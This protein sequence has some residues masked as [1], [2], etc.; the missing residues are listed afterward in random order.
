M[1]KSYDWNIGY[2]LVVFNPVGLKKT[3]LN[4][5]LQ[6]TPVSW[7][8]LHAS[9]TFDQYGCE[10]PNGG[11]NDAG[12]A[13]ELMILGQTQYPAKDERPA[14][15]ELQFIQYALDNFASVE[16]MIEGAALIRISQAYAQVHYL[17]CDATGVCAAFEWLDGEL[18]LAT[19]DD[20]PAPTLANSTYADSA[21]YLAQF[22]G[23]GGSK[24]IPQSISS[25]DRFVRASALGVLGAD[26]EVPGAA[27][28]ILD[29][30]SQGDFSKWNIV[31]DLENRIVHF[32]T[33]SSAAVKRVALS[34]FDPGCES[35]RYVLD[36]DYLEPG[37]ASGAFEPYTLEANKALIDKSIGT[38]PGLPEVA[39][40]I[41]ALYPGTLKCEPV[42]TPVDAEEGVADGVVE[43][44]E[45]QDTAEIVS[46][47]E[48]TENEGVSDA[49][50][51]DLGVT[52]GDSSPMTARG[53]CVSSFR[54]SSRAHSE[55]TIALLLVLFLGLVLRLRRGHR[56]K[57]T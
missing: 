31:Y 12:L 56:T 14:V 39:I 43:G 49:L 55:V 5:D 16:E 22:E 26:G 35:G 33:L 54:G 27:L 4:L 44:A 13:I 23:F 30:V 3:S 29:S 7:T 10:M 45:S 50:P 48:T 32:R 51:P 11:M 42:P 6:E 15:N 28:S 46:W 47:K 18:A 19:G 2:G 34:D 36:I 53:G 1:G 20:M 52:D 21:A 41:L 8:S 17:A 25:L 38:I 37:D 40:E 57:V 24:P 9:L